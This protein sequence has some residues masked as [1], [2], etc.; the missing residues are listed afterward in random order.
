MLKS[1]RSPL[2]A[3]RG[4]ILFFLLVSLSLLSLPCSVRLCAGER[5]FGWPQSV[6]QLNET[7]RPVMKM[8]NKKVKVSVNGSRPRSNIEA[9]TPLAPLFIGPVFDEE[10]TR[11]IVIPQ[12]L[13]PR[14]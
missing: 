11:A 6:P 8:L 4:V 14:C 9:R 10:T 3:L 12:V 13:E 5:Q 2:P 7:E 1:K